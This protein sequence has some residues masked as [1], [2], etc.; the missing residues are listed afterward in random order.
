MKIF[1]KKDGGIVQLI[2]K[3]K[4]QDWP[5]ELPLVF[6]EY[7]RDKQLGTYGDNKVEKEIS[8]YLDEIL[9]DVAIP[10]L[11]SVLEGDDQSEIILA[12]KR[13]EELTKKN[14]DMARPIKPYLEDLMKNK[15]KE[16]VKLAESISDNF[17]K[18][19]RRKELAKKRKIM[20]EKEN[21]FLAGKI[22]GE[23]YA[24]ARREYLTLRD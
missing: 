7:I 5:V 17:Q 12:L 24:N 16:I 6:I 19:D 4:M 13:I 21:Q 23:E 8:E 1:H 22:S 18:A 9:K 3:E 14:I 11:I 20:R 10:R 2:S 15:N